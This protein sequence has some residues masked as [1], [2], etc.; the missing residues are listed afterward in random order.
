[1][2]YR[3]LTIAPT[4]FFAD[5]GAHVRILEEIVHL[6]K[7]G[8]EIVVCTYHTGGDV[9]G[10]TIR[11]SLDVPWKRGV[12]VGSSRHKLYFDV[13]LAATVQREARWFRPHLVHAHLHEGALLGWTLRATRGVPLVFDYQGSMTAEML[14]HGFLKRNS[15]L[16]KPLRALER[17]ID[18]LPD[19]IITSSH[20][21]EK[22]LR[23]A[24]RAPGISQGRVPGISQ[25]GDMS[26]RI[27][28]V[29]DAVNT[30]VFAPPRTSIE[31]G[32]TVALKR[33]LGIPPERR[34][35]V[36]LG[37]LAPYQGTDHLLEAAAIMRNEWGMEDVHFLM[38]GFPGVESY[39]AQADKLNLNDHV[40]FPGRIPYSDAPRYLA[41]GD[42]AVAPKLSATEGAGK[43]GN[44]MAMGLPVV[45]YDTPVSREYL[46][47][48]GV[49]AARGDSRDLAMKLRQVLENKAHYAQVGAQLRQRC[50]EEL[51]WDDA[52]GKIEAVYEKV[53]AIGS[54]HR[55]K[56]ERFALS[57]TERWEEVASPPEQTM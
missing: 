5:Y 13:A 20:N 44:Y 1:L 41:T 22:G 25:G 23:A 38:M 29:P 45:A 36:Y 26:E 33:S 6:Q 18:R 34:V 46:G 55:R 39:R 50:V 43:I 49:Y 19:A 47:G 9:P 3:I 4:S 37:L 28:T 57:G 56:E 16:L 31:R 40:L 17:W 52:I 10:I 24:I 8:H 11:R 51:S 42:V 12:M 35:V 2:P 30:E 53:R 32:A 48:L 14:D 15:R 21:A 54:S 27:T 7:R